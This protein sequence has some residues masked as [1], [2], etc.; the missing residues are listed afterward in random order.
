MKFNNE[1]FCPEAWSQMVIDAEGDFKICCLSNFDDDFGMAIDSS[2]KVMNIA[3]HSIS[4]ALNSETHKSHRL[5][6]AKNLWPKRCRSCLDSENSTKSEN[7]AN[8]KSKRQRVVNQTTLTIPEY[9]TIDTAPLYTNE[10]GSVTSKIVNLDLRFGNLCNQ[11]CIMCSPQH[12]NQW[13][14]DWAAISDGAAVYQKGKYKVFPLIPDDKGKTVMNGLTSWWETEDWWNKFD[15][16]AKD[17]RCIYFTGGEPL[18]VP[19]MQ[20]CLDRLI[21]AGYSKDIELRYDTNL[22]VI[23]NKVIDKWKHFKN[24]IL[25][26]SIDDTQERYELIRF[27]GK[28]DR[29]LENIKTIKEKNIKIEYLSSCIGIASPYSVLRVLELAEQFDVP[30]YFRFL[31]GPDWLDIRTYSA[32]AKIKIIK[33]LEQSKYANNEWVIG[34]IKLLQ[35]YIHTES[36]QTLEKFIRTMEILD[37]RRG[38]DWKKTLPDVVD[39]VRM[40]KYK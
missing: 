6:L 26:I 10:D 5:T 8:G 7:R 18:I 12:S 9:V 29:I 17:L 14:D 23:N 16:I 25:C 39:L 40:S 22:S 11:K 35:K 3:T 34:Q 21:N 32:Q 19:A 31:E 15:E 24:V 1:S 20:E 13:Y 33:T 30:T 27:P 37:E 28:Y 4:E 2:K 38:T 36:R